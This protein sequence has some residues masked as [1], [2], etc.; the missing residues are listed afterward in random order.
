MKGFTLIETLIG[1]TILTIIMFGI[2]GIF[3]GGLRIINN[4]RAKLTAQALANQKLEEARNLPYDKVGTIGGIPAG[5]IPEQIT[6]TRNKINFTVKTTVVYIDD[7]FDE[8]SPVDTLPNDYK[9]VKIKVDWS[10]NFKGTITF[11]TDIAPKGTEQESGGGTLFLSCFDAN[12]LAVA[13]ADVY[14]KNEEVNPTIEA[15]YQTN[16]DGQLIL[17]GSPAS[18]ESYQ[19][20]LSKDGYS[21]DRTYGIEEIANPAK[22]HSSVIE[23]QLTEISFSIDK[24]S[25][26]NVNIIS[27]ETGLPIGNIPFNLQGTKI[28]G[29]DDDDQPVYKYS[30]NHTANADGQIEIP[31]LEWDS[32][33]F[34][35]DKDLTGFDL[36]S[37]NPEQP[38]DLLPDTTTPVTLILGAENTFLITVKDSSTLEPIFSASARIFNLDLGYDQT[39]PTDEQGQA[40]FAPLEE[41]DYNLE[42]QANGYQDYSSVITISGEGRRGMKFWLI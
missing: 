42:I 18:I 40:F 19:I 21:T 23:G 38:V 26:F 39:I 12:G 35:I 36:V 20:S 24:L 14:I 15:N 30:Q 33:N 1:V 31:N 25:T 17:A 37:T 13:Q 29:T 6:V 41:N 16:N 8:I 11:F 10:E 32:Y 22:P 27:E 7:P 28:I 9:R 34:S 2:Y 5:T 4:S 3:Q